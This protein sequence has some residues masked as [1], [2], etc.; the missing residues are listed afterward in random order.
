MHPYVNVV[1]LSVKHLRQNENTQICYFNFISKCFYIFWFLSLRTR[2]LCNRISGIFPLKYSRLAR[3]FDKH[4]VAQVSGEHVFFLANCQTI[5]KTI[6]KIGVP[7]KVVYLIF[8]MCLCLDSRPLI[9]EPCASWLHGPLYESL[10][11]HATATGGL[12]KERQRDGSG[13]Q[14]FTP[15]LQWEV[16]LTC[17][18]S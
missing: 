15:L 11:G 3:S 5:V 12:W 4:T 2:K 1:L 7:E 18:S 9:S 16:T 14:C 13:M 6:K 17:E 10:H 8:G